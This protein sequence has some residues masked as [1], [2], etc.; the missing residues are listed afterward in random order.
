MFTTTTQETKTII[1]F[2]AEQKN[3]SNPSYFGIIL[4]NKLPENIKILNFPKFKILYK[5]HV[6]ET[7]LDHLV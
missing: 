1:Y 3:K 5:G 4:Y 2:L 7:L 6:I